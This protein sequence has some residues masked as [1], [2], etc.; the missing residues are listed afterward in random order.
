[1][2]DHGILNHSEPPQDIGFSL[3]PNLVD[4]YLIIYSNKGIHMTV[5]HC[6][7]GSIAGEDDFHCFNRI[8]SSITMK[9]VDIDTAIFTMVMGIGVNLCIREIIIFAPF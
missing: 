1:M 6:K 8:G 3:S 7:T 2:F 4:N 5:E 9:K